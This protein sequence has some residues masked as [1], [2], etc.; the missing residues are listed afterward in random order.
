MIQIAPK[1]KI[2]YNEYPFVPYLHRPNKDQFTRIPRIGYVL[3]HEWDSVRWHVVATCHP[4]GPFML[5][6]TS[7]GTCCPRAHM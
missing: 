7:G 3:L 2:K 1:I 6:Y 4:H 5:L